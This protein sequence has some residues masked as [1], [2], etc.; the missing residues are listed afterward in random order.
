MHN[1]DKRSG[2]IIRINFRFNRRK[3]EE[4]EDLD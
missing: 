3:E 2:K 4:G 1:I